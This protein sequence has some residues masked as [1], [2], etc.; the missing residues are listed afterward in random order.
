MSLISEC[1]CSR[2][3]ASH[4]SP[5]FHS[6]RASRVRYISSSSKKLS[7]I[8]NDSPNSS[9]SRPRPKKP[10]TPAQRSFLNSAVRPSLPLDPYSHLTF[11]PAAARQPSRR[12]RRNAHIRQPDASGRELAPPPAASDEAHVRSG[13]GTLQDVQRTASEAPRAAHRHVSHVDAGG[14]GAGL[15]HGDHGEGGSDGVHGGGGDGDRNAL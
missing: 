7:T 10:L 1:R 12:A 13:S 4:S 5:L 2:H 3:L 15:G 14:V 9:P 6:P 8:P 11:R